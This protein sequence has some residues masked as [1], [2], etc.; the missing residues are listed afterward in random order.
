[1][2]FEDV[3]EFASHPFTLFFDTAERLSIPYMLTALMVAIFVYAR[4]NRGRPDGGLKGLLPWLFPKDV[5]THP[6]AKADYWMFFIN[7]SLIV[8]IYASIPGQALLWMALVDWVLGPVPQEET[9]P[10]LWISLL[11]TVILA[12]VVDGVLWFAHYI[13]HKVPFLWEFHK[14]HHSAEVMTP[15][16]ATRMHP[17]EELFS[18]SL[19]GA[20]VGITYQL[21]NHAF[22]AEH[23]FIQFLG[24]NLVLGLFFL[25]AF[26]LRHSHVWFQ[27]PYWL[28]H[29]FV[30]PAQHQIHHSRAMKHWDKNMGFIFAF[31]DWGAGTLYAPKG[32]EEIRFGLGNGEDG[33]WNSAKTLYFQPFV[34][35]YALL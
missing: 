20:A 14:T 32:K 33:T 15:L 26:N 10:S 29:I 35:T 19:S 23:G 16:T 11:Y 12:V 22:G 27:Y 1:M 8:A 5:I 6:S 4:A 24:V 21:L 34:N 13:F 31:W 25:A 17:L 18:S 9:A 7:K 3:L 2:T 30:S 28:Q